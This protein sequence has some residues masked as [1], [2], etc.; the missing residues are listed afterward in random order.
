VRPG[1][2][3]NRMAKS[4]RDDEHVREVR[5]VDRTGCANRRK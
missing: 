1:T 4:R 3:A 2:R 5:R